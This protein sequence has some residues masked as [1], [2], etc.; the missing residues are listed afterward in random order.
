[1]IADPFAALVKHFRLRLFASEEEQGSGGMGLG[2]GAVLA[3]LASP[4]AFASIFLMGKYSTLLQWMRGKP[5]DAIKI[6]PPDEYFFVVLSMTITG[7]VMIARWNR[8][9]PDR[10]DF[11]NLAALPIPI[12]NIFLAN[13]AALLSLALTI[14]L[15]LNAVSSV[16]F[17]LFV[18]LSVGTVTA[19][20]HVA[21]A[22]FCSVL[23]ASLFSFFAV[24]ALVGLLMLF[25]PKKVFRIVSL[26]ARILLAVGL[27][28]EFSSD[29]LPHLFAGKL[30]G[31]A[32]A[33][34]K[35]VPSYWFL[36][37]YESML[38]IATPAMMQ[39]GRQALLGLASAVALSMAAYGLCYRDIFLRL[40]ET[41][42]KLRTSR[43]RPARTLSD[44]LAGTLFRSPFERACSSFACKTMVR[45]EPHAMF[46]GSY[47]GVGLVIIGQA[48][49][50]AQADHSQPNLP[51]AAYLGVP[52]L[53]TFFVVSG[54]RFVF[55]I[56]AALT[57][58]WLFQ[59]S[60]EA[61]FP[62]PR[63]LAK[64]LVLW[65]T[66]PWQVLIMMPAM[67][68][69]YGWSLAVA[70]TVTVVTL[71]VLLAELLLAGF[72]KIPFTCSTQLDMRRLLIRMLGAAFGVLLIVPAIARAER[73]ILV[74][75][76]RFTAW[77]IVLA[78]GWLLLDRYGPGALEGRPEL[79]FEDG[80]SAAFELL[81]LS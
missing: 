20:L 8:L 81:K 57:A 5:L 65:A 17:P 9:F 72:Q 71:T 75:P 56:P 79:Q 33:F 52:L 63:E 61:P 12:R 1:M 54:L 36:G 35:W 46:F 21:A 6:S 19:F 55:D 77:T 67:A 70:H 50:G 58:N 14:G 80:P 26:T 3:I 23:S 45:S 62:G 13:L 74:T 38:G 73:W 41:F 53:I 42:D 30:P 31:G 68:A 27:L 66:V 48:A 10:R 37:M 2:L 24:F 29:V 22:N 44:G 28:S 4:G 11:S 49:I 7:L 32:A 34:M 51:S 76:A 25:V 59:V 47:L 18:G 69:E 43:R 15:V 64:R 40:P 39:L 78:A 16:L 60:V